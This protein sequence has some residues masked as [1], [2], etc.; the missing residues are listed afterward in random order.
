MRKPVRIA[1]VLVIMVLFGYYQENVKVA[2]N[3]RIALSEKYPWLDQMPGEQKASEAEKLTPV[4]TI[5]YYYGHE[6]ISWLNHF[7]LPRLRQ[8]K[9]FLTLV[10]TAVFLLLNGALARATAT[11]KAGIWKR[12]LVFYGMIFSAALA[13][14]ALGVGFGFPTEAYN[15][16]RK[17]VGF[18]Q[19]PMPFFVIW[20]SHKLLKKNESIP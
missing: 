14:Y 15:V 7:S 2:L 13:F 17:M 9:W 8:L 5:D 16:S 18:L 3:Y 20:L 12:L 4:T 19:S 6:R 10:F 11:D 1:A